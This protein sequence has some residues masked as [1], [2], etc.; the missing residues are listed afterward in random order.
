MRKTEKR[1]GRRNEEY[2]TGDRKGRK[3]KTKKK[4]GVK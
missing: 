2:D 1:R 4:L 3:R